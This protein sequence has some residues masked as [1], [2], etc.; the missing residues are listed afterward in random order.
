MIQ[1]ISD[2]GKG[3]R[4][5]LN[6]ALAERKGPELIGGTMAGE[7]ARELAHEFGIARAL[8]PSVQKPV[9][10]AS[11]TTAP[12]DR[13]TEGDWRR[14]VEEYLNRLGYGNSQWVMVRHHDTDL[15]HV[16][17]IANRV[18]GHGKR[19]PDFQERKRGEGI[20]R[21]LELQSGLTQVAPSR[22]ARRAAPGRSELAAFARTGK[23]SIKARLQE[24]VDVAA[25][26]RPSLPVLVERLH[27]QGVEVQ[28]NV[29]S[30]GRMSGLSFELEGVR[31]KGSDLGRG[32]SWQGWP[33]TRVA[34]RGDARPAAQ[35]AAF[36]G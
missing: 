13:L 10:H 8:N 22:E 20:V 34:L 2:P 28:T 7:T 5:A 32:Y 12:A 25:R 4:G 19:V 31:C 35:Q 33:E 23:V 16:H 27:A 18:D 9:F 3:F 6:Y 1:K 21:D 14:F 11:L 29:A 17:I 26:D 15:D 24:H 36:L 30:T